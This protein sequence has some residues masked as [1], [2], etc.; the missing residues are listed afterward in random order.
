MIR[1][2]PPSTAQPTISSNMSRTSPGQLG[3][4]QERD[5]SACGAHLNRDESVSG[6]TATTTVASVPAD[7]WND[8][9]LPPAFRI[10]FS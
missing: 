1:S 10:A 3:P 8:A 2:A 4:A 9:L 6:S 5:R 7:S